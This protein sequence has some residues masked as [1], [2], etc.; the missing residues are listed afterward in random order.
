MTK[1]F[2]ETKKALA[3]TLLSHPHHDALTSLTTDASDQAVGAVFQ[4]FVNGIWEPL[5]FFS[6]KLQPPERK[7]SAFDRELLALYLGIQHFQY[8]LEGRRF[9]AYTDHNPLTFCM[10]KTSEPWSAVN[11]ANSPTSRNSQQTSDKFMVR[12]TQLPSLCRELPSMMCSWGYRA[13]AAAQ[14]QDAEVQAYRTA[15]SRLQLEDIPF[16]AQGVTLLCDVSTGHAQPIVPASWRCQVFDLIHG[17]THP[18]VHATRKLIASN[19][20]WNGLQKHVGIWAKQ[21]LPCQSSKIHKHIRAPLTKFRVPQGRFDHIH[22]DLV[23][24]LP[25]SNGFTHLLTVVD[26]LSRWPEAT[27]LND[28]T[29][30]SC[31]HA[32][33]S[34]WIARLGIPIDMSSDRGPQFTSQLWTAT[35]QLLGTQLTT[36]QPITLNQTAWW[37][38]SI[39]I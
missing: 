1:A 19:F 35:A 20:V 24:P 2:Q 21:C 37:R 10:S 8:F 4:Q 15:T 38:G 39:V 11:N 17:F 12:T 29:T 28:T 33:V 13:M 14:Q 6:K 27:P 31:A 3:E 36:P 26:R 25:P 23:G 7:Y 32:L 9:T 5:A 18:S 16:G 22:V 30:T 34:H